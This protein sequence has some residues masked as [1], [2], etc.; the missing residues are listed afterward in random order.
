MCACSSE[1]RLY[2]RL[3]Q[4]KHGQQVEGGDSPPLLCSGETTPRV[5]CPALE[6]SAQ[7]RHRS[8]GAH[9]EEGRKNN[10]RKG[11]RMKSNTREKFFVVK[12]VRHWNRLPREAVEALLEVFKIRWDGA[13]SNL[14]Q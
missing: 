11:G 14:I 6:L 8:I 12:V 9:P 5:L 13:L 10:Q 2:P 1:S 4:K 3:H 7:E